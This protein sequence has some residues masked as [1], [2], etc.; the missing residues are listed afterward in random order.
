MHM[1]ISSA[2]NQWVKTLRL[3][4][5]KSRERKQSGVFVID[6][7]KEIQMAMDAG[8]EVKQLFFREGS[9]V[10]VSGADGIQVFEIEKSLF[11][12]LSYRGN[13][14]LALAI[15]TTKTIT[16]DEIKLSKAPL[17]LIADAVEKPGNIGAMLRTVDATGA[18]ALIC[19]DTGT[20]AFNPNI[21]RS[22]VGCVFATQFVLADRN[23]VLNWLKEKGIKIWTTSLKASIPYTEADFTAPSAIVLGTEASGVDALWEEH[24]DANIILPML[25]KNDS[26]NVSNTAAVVLYEALR[27]RKG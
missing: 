17:L 14:S 18:D 8:F 6:G 10:E 16:L 19:C 21:I 13:T 26:L 4:G 7:W 12:K 27:Q 20:D 2:Q 9:S 23:T 11:D 24:S 15:V 5:E 1:L 25:G 22:S 3:L